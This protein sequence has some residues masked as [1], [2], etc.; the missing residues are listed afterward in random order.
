MVVNTRPHG[1]D[2]GDVIYPFRQAREQFGKCDAGFTMLLKL[3]GA[4]EHLGAGLGHL[5]LEGFAGAWVGS[6]PLLELPAQ[7]GL[8]LGIDLSGFLVS[9]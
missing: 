7:L 5:A 4:P 9:L 8:A 6:Q 3:P 1:A 2:E